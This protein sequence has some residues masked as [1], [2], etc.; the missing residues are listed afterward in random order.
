MT[1]LTTNIISDPT[2]RELLDTGV[3]IGDPKQIGGDES[4]L[5]AVVLATGQTLHQIDLASPGYEH[6]RENP[7][8]LKG[9]TVVRDAESFIDFLDKHR[10]PETDIFADLYAKPMPTVTAVF[11]A[12]AGTGE[13]REGLPGW[14]DHR[15][16]LEVKRTV[17]WEAWLAGQ[18]LA[19]Q[20]D[21]AEHIEERLIDI[22][23]PE[24]AVMLELAQSFQ[25]TVNAEFEQATFLSSS[26][27]KFVYRE[28]VRTEIEV[29]STFEIGLAPFDGSDPIRV[30]CRLRYKVTPGGLLI[31]YLIERPEDVER[32]AFDSII[33][34]IEVAASTRLLRGVAVPPRG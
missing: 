30:V 18:G 31:G 12:A 20:S 33:E 19:S 32:E 15:L 3:A 26:A 5:F 27:R 14:G 22:V 10:L 16:E 8:R 2:V 24:G 23:T 34:V 17:A 13:D 11:N 21:F 6:L 7:R 9:K 4:E 1:D 29:P 28:D 25:A